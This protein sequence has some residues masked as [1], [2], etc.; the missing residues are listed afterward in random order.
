MG[1]ESRVKK[2]QE[3]LLISGCSLDQESVNFFCKEPDSMYY[4]LSGLVVCD[5]IGIL[6]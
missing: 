5:A 2:K 6:K 4:K 1:K 3:T